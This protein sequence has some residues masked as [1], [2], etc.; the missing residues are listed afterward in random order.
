M[1]CKYLIIMLIVAF[2]AVLGSTTAGFASILLSADNF[3][4]LAGSTVTNT[5]NST[6]IGDIGVWPL[7]AYTGYGTVTQTGAQHLGDAVAGTAQSD[8]TTAFNSLALMPVNSVLTG[9]NLGGLTLVPGVYKFNSEALLTGTLFLDAQ[10]NNNAYWVF[11]I[12]TTLITEPNAAVIFKNPGSNAGVFWQVGSSATLDTG[13]T[14]I[15]NI[16][17][18]QMI[19]LNTG[20]TLNGR[21]LARI[22][23]VTMQGNTINSGNGFNGGLLP[24][25]TPEP[26]SLSLL[27][28]GLLGLMGFKK[29]NA[30]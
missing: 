12:G 21:A 8:V 27:G 22:A 15:G 30:K 18:D 13:T 14:F 29:R 1:K 3:A 4:V 9:Q 6:V 7:S 5:G 26:A 11:Q 2:A 24:T 10:G 16:L 17:A 28:L 20:A 25:A 19:A 23:A